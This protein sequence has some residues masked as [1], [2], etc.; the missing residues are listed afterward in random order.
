MSAPIDVW[1]N[2]SGGFGVW[3]VVADRPCPGEG[4]RLLGTGL[5][6][7]EVGAFVGNIVDLR[8]RHNLTTSFREWAAH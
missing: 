7:E 1:F 5:D 2:D 3:A 6:A 4:W 8:V